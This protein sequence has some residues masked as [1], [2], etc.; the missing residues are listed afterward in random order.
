MLLRLSGARAPLP[1]RCSEQ[2]SLARAPYGA[3]P[4]RLHRDALCSRP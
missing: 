1:W 4:L 3:L 2:H